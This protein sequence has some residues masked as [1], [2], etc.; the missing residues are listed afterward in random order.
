MKKFLI[1][2]LGLA[3]I[4]SFSFA[5]SEEV[6][7]DIWNI[8][9]EFQDL[10]Q[11]EYQK[12]NEFIRE[13]ETLKAKLAEFQSKRVNRDDMVAKLKRE[14]EIRWHRKEFKNL[15]NKYEDFQKR[16]DK[17]IADTEEKIAELDK[18]IYILS[19]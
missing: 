17:A 5:A 18:L 12:L 7:G 1:F 3:T 13:R 6:I 8:E 11:K 16:L 15:L 9:Q 19:N 2:M 14:S 4:S 10:Q